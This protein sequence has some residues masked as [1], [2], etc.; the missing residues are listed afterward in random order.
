ML[1][2]A[3]SKTPLMTPHR[4]AITK[5]F[6]IILV[7]SLFLCV[8]S[9]SEASEKVRSGKVAFFLSVLLPGLGQ[10]YAGDTGGARTFLGLEAAIWSATSAFS[11]YG[12]WLEDGYRNFAAAHSGADTRAKGESFFK[13]MGLHRSVY[14][15]NLM[16][17]W[18]NG[19]E[20]E[21]YPE[22]PEWIWEWDSD[23]SMSKYSKLRRESKSAYRRA[24]FMG[25][26][27]AINH[28]ISAV[29]ASR[30][31][32]KPSAGEKAILDVEP[33]EGQGFMLNLRLRM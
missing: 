29:H 2:R 24:L 28:F 9:A 12:G 26:A 27:V 13:D 16:A 7:L 6:T 22:S 31:V 30:L 15:H 32:G 17:R 21:V 8:T 3:I 18:E 19:P 11:I 33:L 1:P 14:E 20:A 4:D 23:R 25:F 10:I 5:A